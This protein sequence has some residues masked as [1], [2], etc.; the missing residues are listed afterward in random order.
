MQYDSY[1]RLNRM[2]V[3][4]CRPTDPTLK[5]EQLAMQHY[6]VIYE[7]AYGPIPTDEDGRTYD[8]HHRDGN[9]F[10]NHPS[11]LQAL[12][13]LEHYRVHERQGDVGA[14]LRLAIELMKTPEE[15][16][17][18]ASIN[19]KNRIARGDHPFCDPN[20]QSKA[21]KKG[22]CRGG[23]LGGARSGKL[24]RWTNGF[25]NKNCHECPGEG[26][27]LGQTRGPYKKKTKLDQQADI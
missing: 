15:I 18:L 8:I 6:R 12:S 26:W 11:N 7:Q 5:G 9:R 13:K 20:H 21:G 23:I 24:P 2:S 1:A 4:A 27:W 14:C 19:A 10:N 17:R 22:G 25:S 16:S 3:A